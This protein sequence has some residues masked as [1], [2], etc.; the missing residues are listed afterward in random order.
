[1]GSAGLHVQFPA[2]LTSLGFEEIRRV[3]YG[4]SAPFAFAE[5]AGGRWVAL[6]DHLGLKPLFFARVN[7]AWVVAE[8]TEE[9]SRLLP[10]SHRQLNE[11]SVI[12]HISGPYSPR[13]EDTFFSGISSVPPGSMVQ[14]GPDGVTTTRL[15]DPSTIPVDR[16][17]TLAGAVSKLRHLLREVASDF[18]ADGPGA[19]TLSSGMDSTSVLAALVEAGTDVSAVTWASAEI[20]ESDETHWARLTCAKLGVPLVELQIDA[21]TLLPE[22]GIVTRRSSPL[23][24]M[25]DQLWDTAATETARRGCRTM[26]T[27][28]SGDHL[29]GGWVSPAVDSLLTM[30]LFKTSKYLSRLRTNHPSFLRTVRSEILSPILRQ[31]S[32]RVWARRQQPVPWLRDDYHD[33]WRERQV[34]TVGRGFPPGW[35][36]RVSRFDEAL[37]SMLSEDL[38]HSTGIHGVKIRHPLL[39]RRLVE[40][41]ISMPTEMLNDGTTDKLVL[42]QAMRGILP[43]EIVDLGKISPGPIAQKAMRAREDRLVSL[44]KDMRAADLGFV[45]EP[46]IAENV[47]AFMRG[48]H[49]KMDF[50]PALTLED[51]LRRWW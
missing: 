8:K 34:E 17:L 4:L 5:E 6:T 51:W 45:S 21:S 15:W 43:N 39:D 48:E 2:N 7:G 49:D 19:V 40:F 3:F 27:G 41:A 38:D 24:N 32:P 47:A 30:R 28:F 11:S 25:F 10:G 36:V 37:I 18:R 35:C 33:L 16:T 23:F 14:L 50:W 44:T 31:T 9:I 22:E 42:R 20:P 46:A 1:M 12:G 29:F 13:R 26:F